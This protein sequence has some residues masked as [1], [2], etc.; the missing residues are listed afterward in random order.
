[1]RRIDHNGA[2]LLGPRIRHDLAQELRIDLE[3]RRDHRLRLRLGCGARQHLAV[4]PRR[5]HWPAVAEQEFDEAAAEIGV[6]VGGRIAHRLLPHRCWRGRWHGGLRRHRL[7]RDIGRRGALRDRLAVKL[8]LQLQ[9][10][11]GCRSRDDDARDERN[12]NRFH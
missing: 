6:A 8:G 11:G 7:R 12:D 9:R 5:R 2:G 10:F 3:A 1:M 4:G